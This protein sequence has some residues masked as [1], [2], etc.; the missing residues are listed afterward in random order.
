MMRSSSEIFSLYLEANFFAAQLQRHVGY[1]YPILALRQLFADRD[2]AAKFLVDNGARQFVKGFSGFLPVVKLGAR[3]V[4]VCNGL[5]WWRSQSGRCG[6]LPL[7]RA[8]FLAISRSWLSP[9]AV[10]RK[11]LLS[12]SYN[13]HLCSIRQ[14]PPHL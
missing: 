8:F 5:D 14:S 12:L 3:N 13:R 11:C 1:V 4:V 10:E 9:V 6:F 7:E 2:G